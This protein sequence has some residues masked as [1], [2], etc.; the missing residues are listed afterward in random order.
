MEDSKIVFCSSKFSRAHERISS[1]FEDN[2]CSAFRQVRQAWSTAAYSKPFS[3]Q[4]NNTNINSVTFLASHDSNDGVF[5]TL[6]AE[7]FG[8][9]LELAGSANQK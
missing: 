1:K 6:T 3:P 5:L 9:L 2:L 4:W 8:H 7:T